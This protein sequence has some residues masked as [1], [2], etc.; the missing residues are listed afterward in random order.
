MGCSHGNFY[1]KTKNGKKKFLFPKKIETYRTNK[2]IYCMIPV[3]HLRVLLGVE[4]EIKLLD[5]T[6]I[7]PSTL[8]QEHKQKI[9]TL[10]KL[11]NSLFAS[12][13]D[14]QTIKIWDM[15]VPGSQMT[16]TGHTA[17]ISCLEKINDEKIISGSDDNKIIVWN[18]QE[19]KIDYILYEGQQSVAS[20][21]LL[22]NGTIL[23][24]TCNGKLWFWN[25]INKTLEAE[26]DIVYGA[27]AMAETSEGQVIIGLRNGQIQVW[28]FEENKQIANFQGHNNKKI[29]CILILHHYKF[30]SGSEENDMILWNLND[31]S[32]KFYIKGHSKSVTGIV[33]ID[34]H[35]F[36]SCS[37]DGT[38]QL[39]E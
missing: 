4:N 30:I 22:K 6:S 12:G 23:S 33:A 18:L 14:D 37:E 9:T 17:R 11:S 36:V 32:S 16:L 39:W 25:M 28:D 26:I 21:L 2:P 31:I 13:S 5:I 35:R 7:A 29:N 27:W 24:S 34:D 10:L 8:F 15:N 20:L 19:K 38:I 1:E 3:D